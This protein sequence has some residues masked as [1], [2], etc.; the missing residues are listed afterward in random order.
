MILV[1]PIWPLYSLVGSV[2]ARGFCMSSNR[3]S[4]L[5]FVERNFRTDLQSSTALFL[6]VS[7]NVKPHDKQWRFNKITSA[8]LLCRNSA[9]TPVLVYLPKLESWATESSTFEAEQEEDGEA[10]LSR[11]HNIDKPQENEPHSPR[12]SFV[13]HSKANRR[14]SLLPSVAYEA[15]SFGWVWLNH[16]SPYQLWQSNQRWLLTPVCCICMAIV[17]F[18]SRPLPSVG[19]EV[20]LLCD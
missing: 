9:E 6:E 19:W 7:P 5:V 18:R 4:C 10:D 12:S 11:N 8:L 16:Q 2:Y 15:C 1:Q 14:K 17:G 13:S 20:L 3:M